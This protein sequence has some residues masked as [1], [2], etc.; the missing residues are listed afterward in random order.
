LVKNTGWLKGLRVTADG[1]GVVS[2]AG[3]ALIRA[4]AD[5]TGL[6]AGLSRALADDRLLVHDRGRVLAG[7]ACVIA[8]GGEA[9][10]DFRVVG[11]QGGLFGPVASVPV[12]WRALS[13]IGGGGART[14]GR[15]TAA[16]N[17]ARR[18]A[19]A[20]AAARHGG[21]P[22]IRV[23]DKI[24]ASVTCIRLDAS[25]V[26]CHSDKELAEPNF[27]GF[28][29]HRLLACCDNTGE[30]LAGM[31][32]RGAAGSNTVAGHLPVL[33]AAIAALPPAQRR[34]LMVTCDGAGASHGLITRLDQL[35]SRR[36]YQLTYST[37]WELGE[38]ERAA[39]RLVP[40]NAWQICID[41]HGEVRER[42]A[43][44]A[45][46]DRSCRHRGCWIQEARVTELTGILRP[47]SKHDQ[48]AGWPETMRIFARR[49]RPHPGAQLSLFETA[50]GW[51]YSLRVTNLPATARSWRANPACIDAPHRERLRH[52][53]VSLARHRDEQGL[54]RRR[55]HRRDAAGL[56]QA[57]RPGRQARQSRAEDAAVQDPARRRAHHPRRPQPA[58]QDPGQLAM[59]ARHGYRLDQDQRPA[60]RALTAATSPSRQQHHQRPVE[61]PA[62]RPASRAMPRPRHKI[63]IQNA[64]RAA[65][66][67]A[68][69]AA[70]MIEAST[71]APFVTTFVAPT[72]SALITA[73]CPRPG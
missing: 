66:A 30:P 62:T 18:V 40:P 11:D 55:A 38:R 67:T 25:V 7:L 47:G 1:T 60:A 35:S 3:V 69:Q 50:D 29:Y 37:G 15:V 9:I 53:P 56:A 12:V 44:D 20:Q 65:E 31:L 63:K 41:Q 46:G 61:P 32:R 54:V 24:L 49:E 72:S 19:W 48:L 14:A 28:G 43:D 51:R 17:T 8:D 26:T 57:D 6:T 10:S 2:H 33:D 23:A 68:D 71:P 42:R 4:L 39:I 34:N 5:H 73:L 59:G 27:K 36:G 70:R 52:R 45:C 22:G 16:V 21:L 64:R 13:E 58:P